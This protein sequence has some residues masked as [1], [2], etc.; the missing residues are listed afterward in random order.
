MTEPNERFE[1]AMRVAL[2]AQPQFPPDLTRVLRLA[3]RR[4]AAR[5]VLALVFGRIWLVLARLF[6][7]AVARLHRISHSLSR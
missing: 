3:R 6:A 2:R 7:P 1:R 4:V 5:S